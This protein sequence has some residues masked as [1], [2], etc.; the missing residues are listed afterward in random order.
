MGMI[1][2][3]RMGMSIFRHPARGASRFIEHDPDPGALE[4]PA[5]DGLL[6]YGVAAEVELAESSAELLEVESRIGEGPERHISA[7]A[8]EGL[9]ISDFCHLAISELYIPGSPQ[10]ESSYDC[11]RLALFLKLKYT[12]VWQWLRAS[13][14]SFRC[15]LSRQL[16]FN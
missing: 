7:A 12:L 9:K 16:R 15:W 10:G 3:V 13:E 5:P 1:V 6:F 11:I 8:A 14:V 4:G 2:R